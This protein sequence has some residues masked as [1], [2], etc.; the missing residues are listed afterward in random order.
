MKKKFILV[1]LT[2]FIF[3]ILFAGCT[4]TN[5]SKDASW[6]D[7]KQK[8][9]FVVGLDDSFPPMGFKDDK[10]QIVG[11]DID[12]AKEAAKRMGVKVVFKP[13]Q[14]DGVLL[15]LKNKDID[16]IWNGL[17]ITDKRKQQIAFSKPYLQ[18][19]QIIV[20]KNDSTIKNKKDLAQK[21]VGLQLGSSSETAL[22][23]D[24]T[25]LKSLKEVKK[26]SDNTEAL[27]DL[28]D[29]RVDAVVADEVVARYYINKTKGVYKVLND[30]FKKEEY[31]VGI[32]KT[33]ISFK[34][35]LDKALDDMKKDGTVNKISQKW[36][37]ESVTEK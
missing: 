13:V 20:V 30:D 27:M 33:D 1:T 35:K 36:F 3:S 6:D 19:K 31:G 12:L 21:K 18:N 14:W 26:Y 37:G 4:T 15:S 28:K 22:K 23:A 5:Q 16:V 9:Q 34:E 24:N 10:G 25:T 29:G 2:L 8:G 11:F 32:R 17:T 7:I